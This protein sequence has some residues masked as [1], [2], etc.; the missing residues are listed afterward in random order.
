MNTEK[1]A[2]NTSS[3]MG[4]FLDRLDIKHVFGFQASAKEFDTR[5]AKF[6]A[7]V[8]PPANDSWAYPSWTRPLQLSPCTMLKIAAIAQA[9]STNQLNKL[10]NMKRHFWGT[11]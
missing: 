2:A 9:E 10:Q 4:S 1:A 6:A 11:T 5:V 3:E 7:S 8:P